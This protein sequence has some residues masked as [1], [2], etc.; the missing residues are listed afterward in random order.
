MEN[1]SSDLRMEN[2]WN[3]FESFDLVLM[4]MRI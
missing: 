1:S 4:K 3:S 2:N